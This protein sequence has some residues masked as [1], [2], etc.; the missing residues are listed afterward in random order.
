MVPRRRQLMEFSSTFAWRVLVIAKKRVEPI[1]TVI[2]TLSWVLFSG[3]HRVHRELLHGRLVLPR[4][5]PCQRY[6][7]VVHTPAGLRNHVLV[8]Y[9]QLRA[10]LTSTF[11]ALLALWSSLDSDRDGCRVQEHSDWD[12]CSAGSSPASLRLPATSK[13]H[14]LHGFLIGIV[15]SILVQAQAKH[16]LTVPPGHCRVP[17]S[18]VPHLRHFSESDCASALLDAS[19]SSTFVSPGDI[20]R[21]TPW[22]TFSGPLGSQSFTLITQDPEFTQWQCPKSISGLSPC[23]VL[24]VKPPI[25]PY[26]ELILQQNRVPLAPRRAGQTCWSHLRLSAHSRTRHTAR[27]ASCVGGNEQGCQQIVNSQI[28]PNLSSDNPQ[29]EQFSRCHIH[30]L[31][32]SDV[33]PR[34]SIVDLPKYRLFLGHNMYASAFARLGAQAH[35]AQFQWSKQRWLHGTVPS[36]HLWSGA[37]SGTLMR[38]AHESRHFFVAAW[39]ANLPKI[40]RTQCHQFSTKVESQRGPSLSRAHPAGTTQ[41]ALMT[42]L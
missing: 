40:S 38:I 22:M 23:C 26:T 15:L 31:D 8:P 20:R 6:A 28:H 30:A 7:E 21:D 3:A 16:R 37:R 17:I 19:V 41:V 9:V 27:F 12:G 35:G 39:R 10:C 24:Q 13:R 25:H 33:L 32:P 34:S 36:H 29:E 2:S 18:V 11:A 1:A 5:P 14:M 4:R 42:P